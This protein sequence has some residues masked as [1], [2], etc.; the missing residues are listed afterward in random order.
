MAARYT[1]GGSKE[2]NGAMRRFALAARALAQHR[3]GMSPAI[4]NLVILLVVLA[5]GVY[6]LSTLA[7]EQPQKR[8]EKSVPNEA[9][10]R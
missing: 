9:L 6:F 8:V 2:Q 1:Q 4:R 7:H 10:G 5:G 3:T